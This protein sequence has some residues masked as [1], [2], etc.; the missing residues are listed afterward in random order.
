MLHRRVAVLALVASLG[1]STYQG[2]KT[3]AK[4]GGVILLTGVVAEAV[5]I[6]VASGSDN[7]CGL[8]S[9]LVLLPILPIGVGLYGLIAGLVGMAIHSDDDPPASDPVPRRIAPP[10]PDESSEPVPAQ[11]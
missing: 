1:C 3:T 11:P 6:G 9:P 2:S 8:A 7:C 4:V 10:V 5:V